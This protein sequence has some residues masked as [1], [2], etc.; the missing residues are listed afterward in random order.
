MIERAPA[1]SDEVIGLG[2]LSKDKSGQSL[3]E[4]TRQ[5]KVPRMEVAAEYAP[6]DMDRT[7]RGLM[8]ILGV[9]Q[10]EIESL[11]RERRNRHES[12]RTQGLPN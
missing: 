10:E 5:S 8:A 2:L 3:S 1:A 11:L 6:F 7:L 4:P 12:D 9:N